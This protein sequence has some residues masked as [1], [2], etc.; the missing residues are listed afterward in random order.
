MAKSSTKKRRPSDGRPLRQYAA[1]P[2][3]HNENGEIEILVMS[4]RETRRAVVPKG[5]PIRNRK[6]WKTAEIE[7]RQEAGLV[8]EIARRHVG[9]Y[10]YWKRMDSS[11]VLVK[12]S[13]YPLRV[14]RQLTEWPEKHERTQ[15]WMPPHDAATLI[16]ETELGEIIIAFAQSFDAKPKSKSRRRQGASS[17]AAV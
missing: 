11:F 3:V 12:V 4:S 1:L 14:T 15:S 13:V 8:G 16:D 9:Q 5:W 2:Y 10:R 6:S 7:A 17:Q